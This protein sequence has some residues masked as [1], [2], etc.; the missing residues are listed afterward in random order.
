MLPVTI[1]VKRPYSFSAPK[2]L[3]LDSIILSVHSPSAHLILAQIKVPIVLA[4]KVHIVWK[5]RRLTST[6]YFY[7]LTLYF[8]V[9]TFCFYVSTFYLYVSA[10][11]FS[12][13]TFHFL[14][15]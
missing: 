11:Y 10:L 8:Y 5:P 3:G 2:K 9:S 14:T 1:E 12:V 13:L 15:R 4:F 7:I 6:F